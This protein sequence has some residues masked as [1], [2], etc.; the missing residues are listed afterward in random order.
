MFIEILTLKKIEKGETGVRCMRGR[1]TYSSNMWDSGFGLWS[2][3][4]K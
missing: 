2:F 4:R 3:I 1:T